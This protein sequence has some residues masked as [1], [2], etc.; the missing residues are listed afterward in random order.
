MD[1]TYWHKQTPDKPLYPDLL[2]SRPEHQRQAGK[3]LIVGGNAHGFAAPAE[4]YAAAEAAG[5]GLTRVLL[6]HHVKR[7][8]TRGFIE[9]EFLSSTPSGSFSRQALAELLE[10]TQWADA[11]LLAGDFGHNSETAVLLEKFVQK[12]QGLLVLSQDAVDYFTSA[13]Q[14]ILNR[15][16]TLL[17]LEFSQ[18]QKLAKQAR[19]PQAFTSDMDLLRLIHTLHEFTTQYPACIM[20]NHLN[21][22]VVALSGQ[23]STSKLPNEATTPISNAAA[24]AA[25]WLQNPTQSFKALTTS[26]I[27]SKP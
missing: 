13:N 3:L 10:H 25:W 26:L 14:T 4:A 17:A 24:A 27:K 5:V 2:W 23:V 20:V 8:L 9:A 11:V 6:P 1:R 21:N 18:L 7:L 12:Y 19:F 15:P 16:G 22:A